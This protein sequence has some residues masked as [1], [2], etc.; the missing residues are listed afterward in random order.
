MDR[1]RFKDGKLV[2]REEI[3]VGKGRV[4]DVLCGPDGVIYVLLNDPG[5]IVKIS[6]A[7]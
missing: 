7:E 4:R 3:M 1:L 5:R 6:P 2:E